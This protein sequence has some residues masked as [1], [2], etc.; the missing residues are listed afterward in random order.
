MSEKMHA[1]EIPKVVEANQEGIEFIRFWVSKQ[2]E[3][4]ALRV[5][6][7]DDAEEEAKFW[8]NMLAD[9]V[10]HALPILMARQPENP[11]AQI[12]LDRVM[13]AFQDRLST[14]EKLP[15]NIAERS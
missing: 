14:F 9:I 1:L 11:G 4:I 6:V 7:H 10:R 3:Q 8:G 13:D 5:G 2:Q 15:T 12:L